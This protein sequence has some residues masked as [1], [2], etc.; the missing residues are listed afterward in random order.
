MS[1]GLSAAAAGFSESSR[2][3]SR[4]ALKPA[5]VMFARL[6]AVASIRC[7]STCCADSPTRKEL[8]IGRQ[9]GVRRAL[10]RAKA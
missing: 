1:L 7:R 5:V 10:W 2:I 8:S 4:S 3:T 6:F 9:R